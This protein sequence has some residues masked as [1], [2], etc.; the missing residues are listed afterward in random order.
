[1]QRAFASELLCPIDS[2]V[3]AMKNDYSDDAKEE[4]ADLFQ[5]SPL[6]VAWRLADKGLVGRDDMRARA[7]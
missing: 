4:A 7:F 2:L 1:M 6:V 5:V 3:D